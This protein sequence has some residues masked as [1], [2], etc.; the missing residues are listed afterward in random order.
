MEW[1]KIMDKTHNE[2]TWV[3][4]PTETPAIVRHC[5]KCGTKKEFYCNEKFRLNGNQTHIDIWLIYKCAKC[6][7]TWKLTLAKGIKPGDLPASL[8]G[9]YIDNDKE[10]AWKHAFDSSLLKRHE[11]EIQYGN[12]GYIMEGFDV[13]DLLGTVQVHIRSL[14]FFELKLSALLSRALGVSI[15]QIKRL[16]L[17]GLITASS[18]IDIMKYRLKADI[19]IRIQE[20]ALYERDFGSELVQDLPCP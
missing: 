17:D 20:G 4:T 8:F 13:R 5:S 10:L 2:I 18:E 14:Y 12:V 7:T 6:D 9:Q 15:S 3:V 19:I 11:C 1:V 16:A